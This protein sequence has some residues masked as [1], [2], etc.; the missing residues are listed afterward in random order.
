MVVSLPPALLLWFFIHPAAA[1]WR[2]F[3][4]A[5]TY[6]MLSPPMVVLM[7]WAYIKRETVVGSDL[8]TEPWLI[9][10]G[11]A[12][13]CISI[14]IALKRKRHLTF[15]ILAGLPE[16]AR[17]GLSGKLL[18]EGIYSR[19][20]HPRYVEVVFGLVAYAL[21][22]NHVGVYVLAALSIPVLWLIVVLEERELHQR[23]GEEYAR[24]CTQV[25]RFFPRFR[26]RADLAKTS[27]TADGEFGDDN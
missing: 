21:F 19:I 26:S 17:D 1:F 4:P 10:L 7:A 27:D 20:R 22:A 24:Y 2:R 23:F 12:L 13:F 9:V 25:P 14:W 6:A 8:G 16:L 11:V 3:G 18:T 15:A 5:W